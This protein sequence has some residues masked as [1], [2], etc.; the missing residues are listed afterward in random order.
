[1]ASV[2]MKPESHPNGAINEAVR[3]RVAAIQAKTATPAQ[4]V[5]VPTDNPFYKAIFDESLDPQAKTDAVRKLVVFSGSR[6]ESRERIK[7]YMAFQEYLQSVR[8]TMAVEIIKLQDTETF[9]IL[10]TVMNNLNGQLLD[11]EKQMQPLTDI[12]D[13]VYTLRTNG[14]TLDVFNEIKND[15][16]REEANKLK[17]AEQERQFEE[18]QAKIR[19][20]QDDSAALR[21]QK[22]LFGFGG[23]TQ[24]ARQQIA[25]NEMELQRS[26]DALKTLESQVTGQ[27]AT[28]AGAPGQYA[29]EKA[30]LRELLDLTGEEHKSRQKAL[31]DSA[32]KFV[33][34]AKR[35]IGEVKSHLEN[36]NT[37]VENLLD[38]NTKMTG[39]YAILSEA[40]EDAQKD[41]HEL[42]NGLSVVAEGERAVAKMQ[43]EE[44]KLV[45]D[46]HI[47]RL[48]EAVTVTTSAGAD[49]TSQTIRV[50]GMKDA[51]EATLATTRTLHTQGV[52][53]IADR[54]SSTLQAVASAALSESSSAAKDTLRRMKESTDRVSQRESIRVAMGIADT[55]NELLV[56]LDNLSA[57]GEV[58]RT[59]NDI[60]KAGLADIHANLEK[61]KAAAASTQKDLH[62]SFSVAADSIG[63]RPAPTGAAPA[64][65]PVNPFK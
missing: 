36:M 41:N 44:S 30:M 55:N 33:E 28:A 6:E 19:R 62:D 13:A 65:S 3:N 29:V 23:P 49:L 16:E 8:E 21:E 57:Y 54:L 40:V 9:S 5:A 60:T 59:A 51:N 50:K 46:D 15:K 25:R 34:S 45:L 2:S 12:T 24:G 11:F 4:T 52:A 14:A 61:I 1:M 63:L 10:Q 17:V 39:V 31:V 7:E 32:L 35:D 64:Q 27:D 38:N 43:R 18:I 48:D 37:Q 53:G 42:R 56:A 20:I 22:T 47:R 26:Q 58:Q